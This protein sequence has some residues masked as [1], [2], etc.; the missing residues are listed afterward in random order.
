MQNLNIYDVRV[1]PGDSAFLLDDGKTAI[2]YDSGFGFTGYGI[3]DNILKILGDRQ[4]NYIF[5]THS[6]YDHALGSAYILE[7]YPNTKVVAYSYAA[8]IFKRPGAIAL[9]K[10]LD[11][12]IA[13]KYGVKDYKFLGD[14]LCVDIPVNDGDKITV[15]DMCFTVLNLPGHTKCSTGFYCEEK[16]LLL[17]CETMGVFNGKNR[18]VPSVLVGYNSAL[19]SIDKV[20]SLRV[21]NIIAPHF[22]FLDEKQTA[23]YLNNMKQEVMDAAEFIREKLIEG[24]DDEEIN[25]LYR[26]RY[27]DGFTDEAYPED[28]AKLNTSIMIN[29]IK[30]EFNL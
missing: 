4:L 19:Q 5:L 18:V 2:L 8:D 20:L 24:L 23:F 25:R 15:G 7:R 16:E 6:H 28:A 21:K 13:A 1:Y 11:G 12:K 30:K 29:L 27:S 14:K 22:G 3:A 26:M 9:M 10:E 17:A